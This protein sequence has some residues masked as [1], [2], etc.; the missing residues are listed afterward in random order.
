[1]SRLFTIAGLLAPALALATPS[2]SLSPTAEAGDLVIDERSASTTRVVKIAEVSLFTDASAGLT[3]YVT[4]GALTK[5]D[6]QT[7]IP[8]QVLLVA[9]GAATP[10][11]SAFTTASGA[12]YS[13]S[14][15]APGA[16]EKDLYISY[17]PARFQDPGS[18][19]A[20]ITL[21]VDNN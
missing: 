4:S 20:A 7:P 11:T 18:Y 21:S 17:T 13:W 6:G 19:T 10:A 5:S 16:V 12:T 14:S 2:V 8:L 15:V 1:M 9:R 3:V